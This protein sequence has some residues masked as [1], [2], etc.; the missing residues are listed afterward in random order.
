M[1]GIIFNL[2]EE[3]ISQDY[4]ADAWDDLLEGTPVSGT[5]SAVATYPDSELG[6]IVDSAAAMTGLTPGQLLRYMGR[7]SL[8]LMAARYPELFT[9]HTGARTFLLSLNEVIHPEVRKLYEGA[10]PPHFGFQEQSDGT[11]VMEYHSHRAL[12]SL[13]EGLVMGAADQFGETVTITQPQCKLDGYGFCTLRV[14][15]T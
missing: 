9:M 7:R 4:G 13:A 10:Q 8:P 11:L 6:A 14:T 12:C 1:K 2:I 3:V 15:W 5:Y